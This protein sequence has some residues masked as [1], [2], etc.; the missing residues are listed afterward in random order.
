M[1]V[2]ACLGFADGMQG[3][4]VMPPQSPVQGHA[5]ESSERQTSN[6]VRASNGYA[7]TYN[8]AG[9]ASANYAH[10][11]VMSSYASSSVGASALSEANGE[12]GRSRQTGVKSVSVLA[13]WGGPSDSYVRQMHS[14]V[15][16]HVHVHSLAHGD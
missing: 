5:D 3:R 9:V 12:A 13:D 6:P 8:N 2:T 1:Q 4:V 15:S 11:G 14:Q 10:N 7:N 16:R